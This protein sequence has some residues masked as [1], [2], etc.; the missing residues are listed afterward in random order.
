[1][2][3]KATIGFIFVILMFGWH[4]Y[5]AQRLFY[6]NDFETPESINDFVIY[7]EEFLDYSPPPLHVIRIESGQ[8]VIETNYNRPNGPDTIPVLFGSALLMMNGNKVGEPDLFNPIL[9]QNSGVVTWSINLSNQ[10]GAFNNDFSFVLLCTEEDALNVNAKGYFFTGGGMVGNRMGIW[11]FD[12]ALGE[13]VAVIDIPSGLGPLPNKG[14]FRITY[15]PDNNEWALYGETGQE[16]VNPSTVS[17]FLG[18]AVDSTHTNIEA[19]YFGVRGHSTGVNYFDNILITVEDSIP[20]TAISTN[21]ENNAINVNT[22]SSIS[23]TFS[24]KMN[25]DSIVTSSFLVNDGIMNIDGSISYKDR[26]AV[27]SPTTELSSY[28]LYNVTVTTG[29]RDFAGNFIQN[30][31]TFSFKTG[32]SFPWEIFYPVFIKNR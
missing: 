19:P 7:G 28:T 3:L 25:A 31:Y 13:E 9:D 29:V 20:P 6:S 11:R 32:D 15:N 23:V 4:W 18:S 17:T 16:Y 24:E 22:D 8:L 10:D 26:V 5:G 12:H 2:K 21:P 14:S 30:E 1:M 27:F